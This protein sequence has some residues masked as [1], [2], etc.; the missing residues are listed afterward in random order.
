MARRQILAL[1]IGASAVK[2]IQVEFEKETLFWNHAELVELR[3]KEE[4]PRKKEI[5]SALTELTKGILSSPGVEYLFV[6][7]SPQ[8]FVREL[9][10]PKIPG[11]ELDQAIQLQ[12]KKEI[13]FPMEEAKIGYRVSEL[14]RPGEGTRT[15]VLASAVS[16]KVLDERLALFGEVGSMPGEVLHTP[17]SIRKIAGSISLQEGE[18]VAL[19]DIGASLTEMNIYE[20]FQ[21]KFERKLQLGGNDITEVLL[22]PQ[23]VERMGIPPLAFQEAEDLK[24]TRGLLGEHPSDSARPGFQPMQFISAARPVLERFQNE[25]IR[26]FNYFSEQF[27]GKSVNRVVLMGGGSLLKGLREFLEKRLQ[28]PVAFLGFGSSNVL[29]LS[30]QVQSKTE[31]IFRHHRMLLTLSS[32]LEEK[33]PVPALAGIP[34]ARLVQAGGA[35]L[36]ILFLFLSVKLLGLWNQV[37]GYESRW[38]EMA[39]SYERATQMKE[40]ENAVLSRR[41]LLDDFFIDEPY[42]EDVFRELTNLLPSNFD[43]E[44]IQYLNGTFVITG[45]YSEDGGGEENLSG[46]LAS[47]GKGVFKSG[48]LVSTKETAKGSGVFK[49]QISCKL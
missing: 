8:S 40:L 2:K 27:H 47:L 6:F 30:A 14:N 16:R 26:S 11:R 42:W 41:N 34:I 23:T 1:E 15:H 37:R 17:F 10:L 24:R 9:Y 38:K 18:I 3:E 46:F 39:S 4:E 49:F 12:L 20:N 19:I 21:L 7:N 43:L 25:V 29:Q 35:C 22:N 31:E 36:L 5:L 13:P 45:T 32:W 48:K 33:H 28:M 44:T